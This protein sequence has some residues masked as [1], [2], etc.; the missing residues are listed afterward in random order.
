MADVPNHV[1]ADMVVDFDLYDDRLADNFNSAVDA[2]PPVSYTTANGGH[3]IVKGYSEITAVLR[4]TTTFSNWPASIPPELA[5]GRGKFIPLEYDPPVH[6]GYRKLLTPTF[7]PLR[8][9]QLEPRTRELANRLIDE[10]VDLGKCD[11]MASFGR[12][13]PALM[14]LSIMGWPL[15]RMTE[16]AGWV[17]D[18]QHGGGGASHDP[19]VQET[20]RA[21]VGHSYDFFRGYVE[22]RRRDPRDDITT[23]LLQARMPDGRALTEDEVLDYIFQLLVAGLHTVE[24]ALAFGIITLAG[25]PAERQRLIDDPELLPTAV[26]ELLR[27]EPPAWGTARVVARET[28][29]AGVR[30]LPGD[31][32]LLP[33]QSGNRDAAAFECPHSF[34]PARK[35]NAHLSFGGGPH[36]CLGAPL[37]RMELVVAFDE[38]HKRIPDYALDPERPPVHHMSQVRTVETLHITFGRRG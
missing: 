10:F 21:A 11:F 34:D 15:D 18:F 16:F 5:H 17:D 4:D 2:L 19:R 27:W 32:L 13:L 26:E 31:K 6:T 1:P 36:R 20:R 38:L 28:K 29:I 7:S 33:H 37:A 9:R 25:R 23:A 24:T 22:E 14:F 30:L 3:W 8:M 35:R 12:P